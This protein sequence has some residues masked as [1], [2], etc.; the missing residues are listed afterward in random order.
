MNKF[1]ICKKF[2]VLIL[3][4]TVFTSIKM[5]EAKEVSCESLRD[6]NFGKILGYVTTCKMDETTSIDDSGLTISTRDET[7]KGLYFSGNRKIFY[8]PNNIAGT[9][10]N[11]GGIEACECSLKEITK[12]NFDGLVELKVLFLDVNQIEK[13]T[14]DTF[15]G[16]LKLEIVNL[17]E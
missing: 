4:L 5:S 12:R 16:L 15:E 13:I 2:F 6:T 1:R 8:L 3:L 17:G 7:V 11:L 14:S 10:P 9:F